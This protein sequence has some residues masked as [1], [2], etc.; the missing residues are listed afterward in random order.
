MWDEYCGAKHFEIANIV[1][2]INNQSYREYGE[3][4]H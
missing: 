4:D 2:K 1:A 3:Y